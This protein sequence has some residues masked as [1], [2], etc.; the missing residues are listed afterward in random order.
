V[1]QSEQSEQAEQ[2]EQSG[3]AA[4]AQQWLGAYGAAIGLRI[5]KASGEEVVARWD[6]GPHLLQPFGI[7]HGGVHCTVVE[8]LGS[9]AG[10]LW[11]AG[12]GSVVGVNNSTDFYRAVREGSLRS[13]ATPLHRGRSQQVWVIE[14]RDEQDRLVSRGQLRMQNLS[15]Q[16]AAQD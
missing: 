16:P 5:E 10:S 13:V 1:E 7:V 15:P 8:S 2:A 6:V 9:V 11:L 12:R 3:Q 14:T 4:Q